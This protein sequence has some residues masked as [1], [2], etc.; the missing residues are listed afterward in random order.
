MGVAWLANKLAQ[1][2]ERLEA[3]EIVLAGS[4]TRPIWVERGDSILGDYHDLGAVSC[5]FV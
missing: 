3:G 1:H 4:F 2:G 5:H